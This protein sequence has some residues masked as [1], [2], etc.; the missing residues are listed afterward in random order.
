MLLDNCHAQ[1]D[2]NVTKLLGTLHYG[3]P[4]LLRKDGS[5]MGDS[6]S[7]YHVKSR[8]GK[9]TLFR[10]VIGSSCTQ[11][12]DTEHWNAPLHRKCTLHS[13]CPTRGLTAVP[14]R[15]KSSSSTLS[16]N[17]GKL[18]SLMHWPTN[19]NFVRC[20]IRTPKLCGAKWYLD[21]C[22]RGPTNIIIKSIDLDLVK[23]VI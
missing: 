10:Q 20:F 11:N 2:L 23:F 3:R 6:W 19:C 22:W 5:T 7:S 14:R 21:R 13:P 16:G 15:R 9:E 8:R 4:S 18:I 1:T 12:V 17:H